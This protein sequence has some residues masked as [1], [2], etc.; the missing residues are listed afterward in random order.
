[1]GEFLKFLRSQ[2]K[3]TTPSVNGPTACFPNEVESNRTAQRPSVQPLYARA[4]TTLSTAVGKRHYWLALVYFAQAQSALGDTTGARAS[5]AEARKRVSGIA[6]NFSE[7]RLIAIAQAKNRD[8]EGAR[9]TIADARAAAGAIPTAEERSLPLYAVAVAQARTGDFVGAKQVANS[10][11]SS[12]WKFEVLSIIAIAQAKAEDKNGARQTITDGRISTKNVIARDNLSRA[13]RDLA[14]AEAKI[15]DVV[16]ALQAANTI[17][18]EY[19]RVDAL[20]EIASVQAR[21]GD[22]TG[23]RQT[24]ARAKAIETVRKDPLDIRDLSRRSLVQAQADA[25]DFPGAKQTANTIGG[26]YFRVS[27]CSDIAIAQ[28]RSGDPTGAK[29]TVSEAGKAISDTSESDEQDSLRAEIAT[30]QAKI[31]DITGAR[32]TL[33]TFSK[34]DTE[35]TA[36]LRSGVFREI[37]LAQ[38]RVSNIGEANKALDGILRESDRVIAACECILLV[39]DPRGFQ[40]EWW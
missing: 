10:I 25:G 20:C 17:P 9:R 3:P 32:R 24:I 19:L 13:L 38:A 1:M 26:R 28:A 22:R 6:D 16:P 36:T 31:G 14:V 39:L 18:D 34:E 21:S 12:L 23:A 15:G 11:S 5:L 7:L 40:E 27:A 29:Q 30:T 2:G 8:V 37:A 4:R 33:G 35:S